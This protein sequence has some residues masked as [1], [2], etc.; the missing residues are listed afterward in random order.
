MK[1]VIYTVA[2]GHAKYGEMAMGLGQS[3]ALLGDETPRVVYTD[4]ERPDWARCFSQVV[5]PPVK[6]HSLEKLTALQ[7]TD[8]DQVLALDC[9]M[10]AF[11]RTGPIFDYF[12]GQSFG[13]QGGFTSTGSWHE[14][15]VAATAAKY[16]VAE[17]PKFNGGLLYYDRSAEKLIADAF[18]MGRTY[19]EHGFERFKG[20]G[21]SEEVSVMLAMLKN[22]GQWHVAPDVMDFQSS[23][24]GLVGKLHLDVL[25]NTCR[26]LCRRERVR[27]TE[28]YVFH[29]HYFSKFNLYWRELDKLANLAKYEDEHPARFMARSWK[30]RRSFEKRWL[31]WRGR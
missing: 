25:S 14:G 20:G 21:V 26:F 9:D 4:I 18:E 12:Q 5:R 15:D 22:P 6:R 10:L 28:P 19:D 8:A 27:F 3:L 7:F 24:V 17:I 13:V 30:L 29:A 2:L 1:R 16:G 23:A 31:K 11:K